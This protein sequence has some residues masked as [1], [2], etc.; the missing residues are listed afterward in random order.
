M[1]ESAGCASA[2]PKSQPTW[3]VELSARVVDRQDRVA[4][5]LLK[6]ETP[7]YTVWDLRG[8]WQPW[9][10]V[11]LIGGVEN[12]T[13]RNYRDHLDFRPQPGSINNPIAQMG[14]TFYF[15]S[16][17]SYSAPAQTCARANDAFV[18]FGKKEEENRDRKYASV[19]EELGDELRC[20]LWSRRLQ[21]QVMAMIADTKPKTRSGSSRTPKQTQRKLRDK[22][23]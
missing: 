20:G 17:I 14:I 15:G 11:S 3:S 7:G 16:E 13:D 2:S 18:T 22:S 1:G 23:R 6:S 4:T 5:S 19:Q 9:C 21:V 12:F 10:G 8:Y